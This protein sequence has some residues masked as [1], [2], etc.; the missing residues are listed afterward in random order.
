MKIKVVQSARF[1]TQSL[2]CT[3]EEILFPCLLKR[4]FFFQAKLSRCW[5]H[6]SCTGVAKVYPRC[7]LSR[8]PFFVVFVFATRGKTAQ[9]QWHSSGDS[10]TIIGTVLDVK[11]GTI[12]DRN[13]CL[14]VYRFVGWKLDSHS[15]DTSW[16]ISSLHKSHLQQSNSWI[17]GLF[18][19]KNK[20]FWM[21]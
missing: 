15:R 12:N 13:W 20:K 3:R 7:S 14:F 6:A 21:K 16:H 1:S 4:A 19:V 10:F 17:I 11:E 9:A 2:Y 5:S 18:R 8:I